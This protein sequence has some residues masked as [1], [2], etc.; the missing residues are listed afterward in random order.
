MLHTK[1]PIIDRGVY[2]P[3]GSIVVRQA[4]AQ[5]LPL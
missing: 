4:R 3:I 2:V 5:N 1:C